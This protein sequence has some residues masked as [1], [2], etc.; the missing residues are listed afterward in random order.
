[1]S[2]ALSVSATLPCEFVQEFSY[3]KDEHPYNATNDLQNQ[4][5]FEDSALYAEIKNGAFAAIGLQ[6]AFDLDQ[7]RGF[8]Y[9]ETEVETA[10][11]THY[12]RINPNA[13]EQEA[14]LL[15]FEITQLLF[16]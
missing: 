9:Q 14:I 13:S 3:Q 12:P 8:N 4:E 5:L 2:D 16:H 15:A 11:L 6:Q 1:M 7:K 10:I